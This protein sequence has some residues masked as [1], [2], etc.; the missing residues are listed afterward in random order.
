MLP[1]PHGTLPVSP[2][3]ANGAGVLLAISGL[4]VKFK[5]EQGIVY[6]VNGV[7]FDVR[8]GETLGIIGESGSGK[9]VSMLA[10]M[11]LIST[12]PGMVSGSVRFEGQELLT[13]DEAHRR[14][15]RGGQI[16]MVFQDPMTSLN[17]VL[18][19]G[20]QV[21]ETLRLHLNLGESDAQQKAIELLEAVGIQDARRRY[22]D[23]PHRLSGG[24][25]Q[26]VMIAIGLA[27]HPR[28]L[29]ADEPTTALDVTIQAQI[30]QLVRQLKAD[31]GMAMIWITH[32]FGVI[33]GLADRVIVMYAGNI[34]ESGTVDELF[35]TPHHPYTIGL[36]RAVPRLDENRPRRLEQIEG[37]PPLTGSTG[38]GCCFRLRCRYALDRCQTEAPPFRSEGNHEHQWACWVDVPP[39]DNFGSS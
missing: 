32:D 16:A 12:P 6:A 31:L 34:V 22:S 27:C 25:R 13:M 19:I 39:E 33:A 1:D 9:T 14:K 2:T 4:Q 20:K 11:G 3:P 24:M 5:T 37:S 29:I 7:S 10:V 17:P 35:Y 18:T 30:L 15:I 21:S 36:L 38:P 26:R 23:Y 28:L 8:A